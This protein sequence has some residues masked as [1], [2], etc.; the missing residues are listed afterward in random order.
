MYIIKWYNFN[1]AIQPVYISYHYG[2]IYKTQLMDSLSAVE[3]T[4][5]CQLSKHF[6]QMPN[7]KVL[8]LCSI[9]VGDCFIRG[10]GHSFRTNSSTWTH[11]GC[12]KTWQSTEHQ[13][14]TWCAKADFRYSYKFHWPITFDSHL[15][16]TMHNFELTVIKI[17]FNSLKCSCIWFKN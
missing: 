8:C 3:S 4:V 14:F 13:C 11:S 10:F 17:N 15:V 7:V 6:V 16:W 5:D 2:S 1:L 12:L 9:R